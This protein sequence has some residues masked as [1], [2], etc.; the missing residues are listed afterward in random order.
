M[1]LIDILTNEF[2]LSIVLNARTLDVTEDLMFA[3]KDKVL[4]DNVFETLSFLVYDHLSDCNWTR[5]H[6]HL[7]VDKHSTKLAK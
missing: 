1:C 7:V 3:V 4:N 5:T 6:T 2:I